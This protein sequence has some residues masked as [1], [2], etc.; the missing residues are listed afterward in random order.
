MVNLMNA[1]TGKI[2][3]NL[4]NHGSFGYILKYYY[5]GILRCEVVKTVISVE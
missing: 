4:V 3:V 5:L 2:W 1:W